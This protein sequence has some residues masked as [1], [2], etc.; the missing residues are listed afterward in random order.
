MCCRTRFKNRKE[1]QKTLNF[2]VHETYIYQ[3]KIVFIGRE[4]IGANI[5][6]QLRYISSLVLKID[7]LDIFKL[8]T[9]ICH[10]LHK[11]KYTF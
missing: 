4:L 1:S 11:Q 10:N 9:Y 8:G 2:K 7:Y 5:S 3:S 6:F